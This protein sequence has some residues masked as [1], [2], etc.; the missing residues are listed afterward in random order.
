[1]DKLILTNDLIEDGRRIFKAFEKHK[2]DFYSASLLIEDNRWLFVICE[3]KLPDS[4]SIFHPLINH[5]R[6]RI[7]EIL[8]SE[9]LLSLIS[10]K[11]IYICGLSVEFTKKIDDYARKTGKQSDYQFTRTNSNEAYAYI[12]KSYDKRVR[13]DRHEL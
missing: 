9:N 10:L 13:M 7:Y 1:M 11:D 5:M 2:L 3:E 6:S 12:Y 8:E 4:Y